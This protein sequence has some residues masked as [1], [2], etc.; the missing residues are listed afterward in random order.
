MVL[1]TC[2]ADLKMNGRWIKIHFR[3]IRKFIPGI[4]NGIYPRMWI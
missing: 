2:M 1:I 4:V 3:L